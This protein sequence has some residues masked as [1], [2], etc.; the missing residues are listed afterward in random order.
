MRKIFIAAPQQI[1]TGFDS[2][3]RQIGVPVPDGVSDGSP[4]HEQT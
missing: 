2:I 3:E 1:E 4:E